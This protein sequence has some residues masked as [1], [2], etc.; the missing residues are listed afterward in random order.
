MDRKEHLFCLL[1]A[2]KE[3]ANDDSELSCTGHCFFPLLSR[4]LDFYSAKMAAEDRKS[5]GSGQEDENSSRS[6]TPDS[7][8]PNSPPPASAPTTTTTTSSSSSSSSTTTT[9]KLSFGISSILGDSY[10]PTVSGGSGTPGPHGCLPAVAPSASLPCSLPGLTHTFSSPSLPGIAIGHLQ[11][12]LP[13]PMGLMMPGVI[14]VPAHRPPPM[15]PLGGGGL[16]PMMFPWMENRKDRLGGE[17]LSMLMLPQLTPSPISQP[18]CRYAIDTLHI[19]FQRS[20]ISTNIIYY[21]KQT[22]IP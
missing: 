15:P 18:R 19:R 13:S 10:K 8:S 17:F 1:P 22:Y 14:K 20:R 12:F 7:I 5:E 2:G 6:S 16:P 11:G 3:G 4:S 9:T 21:I